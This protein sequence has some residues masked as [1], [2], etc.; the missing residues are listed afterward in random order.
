[1]SNEGRLHSSSRLPE[2]FTTARNN[3]KRSHSVCIAPTKDGKHK[4]ADFEKVVFSDDGK[5]K[6]YDDGQLSIAPLW[7]YHTVT[8]LAILISVLLFE[9]LYMPNNQ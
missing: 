6:F 9:A 7:S 3:I 5:V 1:M 8:V 4:T 2:S